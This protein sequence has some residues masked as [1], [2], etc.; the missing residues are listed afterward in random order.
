MAS[1]SPQGGSR[2]ISTRAFASD[3]SSPNYTNNKSL[4]SGQ[5]IPTS[6]SLHYTFPAGRRLLHSATIESP[7]TP[8]VPL[9]VQRVQFASLA[10]RP[11]FSN[12][13]HLVTLVRWPESRRKSFLTSR[14]AI[15]RS[16]SREATSVLPA[17][18]LS[19]RIS[20]GFQTS[21]SRHI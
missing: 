7:C 9:V 8:Q 18:D 3:Y 13:I 5:L 2:R 10:R 12:S 4:L 20:C 1:A 11:S 19:H 17:D 16:L 6:H 21:G 14:F 15:V